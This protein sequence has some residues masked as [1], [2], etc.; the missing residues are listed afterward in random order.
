MTREHAYKDP[1]VKVN[2]DG[3]QR[4]DVALVNSGPLVQTVQNDAQSLEGAAE[5]RHS[6]QVPTTLRSE[7]THN[8]QHTDTLTLTLGLSRK[9]IPFILEPDPLQ[10]LHVFY[11]A[12][13]V[14]VEISQVTI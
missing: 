12:A 13:G 3:E 10:Y 2:A 4:V 1:D 5:T 14:I 7:Q 9:M 6:Q 8:T 11:C